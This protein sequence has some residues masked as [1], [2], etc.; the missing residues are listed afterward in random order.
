M[1]VRPASRAMKS[2]SV[3]RSFLLACSVLA[4]AWAFTGR[5]AYSADPEFPAL[6]GR[7]V[8][9]ANLLNSTEINELTA[10]LEALEAKSTDQLVVVTLPSLQG[11]EIE[12]FGYKLGRHWGI[13][14]KDKNNG[15]LL[16]VAVKERKMRIE[17]G[18]G[19]EPL[20]TD[21]LTKLIIENG[22]RPRFKS[23]DFPGGI[24]A[25]VSDIIAV[26]TGDAE[27]LMARA[28]S[29]RNDRN[30]LFAHIFLVL[31][32]FIFFIILW[33][34]IQSIRHGNTSTGTGNKKGSSGWTWGSGGS[35]GGG[36]SSGGGGFSGGG[37]GFGGG[38]SS[39]GW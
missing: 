31:W 22:I 14:Q 34:V 35:S 21:A 11:F 17:V 1:S 38:G 7:V 6:T 37:G 19:L 23:G 13:G 20:L 4:L 24:K 26:L 29:P 36:W 15:V 30:D 25:G 16:I 3:L 28:R 8:D 2:I 12:E 9:N 10:D 27:E 18:R 39:G 33:S 32:F 5:P